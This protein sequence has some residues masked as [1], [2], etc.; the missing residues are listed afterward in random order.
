MAFDLDRIRN[1]VRAVPLASPYPLDLAAAIV[2]DALRL[3]RIVPPPGAT[4]KR[5]ADRKGGRPLL[6]EQAGMLAHF[7][8]TTS[9]R[10][11]T[12]AAL[13]RSSLDLEGVLAGFFEA[14]APLTSEMIRANAFR[15]EEFLR[16]WIACVGGRVAGEKPKDSQRR[17]EQ[18]DYRKTLEEY[19]RAEK[20][21][22]EEAERRA[23]LLQEAAQREA[24]A[25]GW[26]E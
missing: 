4:W 8:A 9:L 19:G 6:A 10:E 23:K 26:R 11:E 25:R 2:S 14:I 3:A 1:E 22:K 18:L 7:L 24:D 5:W 13:L 15:E 17:L 21:R 20:A 16:R 12:V